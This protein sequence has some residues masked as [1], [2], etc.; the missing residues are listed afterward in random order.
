MAAGERRDDRRGG[1]KPFHHKDV[2]V[3][4]S[5]TL[6]RIGIS[7]TLVTALASSLGQTAPPTTKDQG[8]KAIVLGV[9]SP[10]I[11][12]NRSGTSIGIVARGTLYVFDAGPG[13]ERRVLEAT[14]QM[15]E[16]GIVRK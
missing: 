6:K 11:G 12:P 2:Q 9:G 13:V 8:T 15:S 16:L 5:T 1:M 7:V 3:G 14:P 4:M 10:V